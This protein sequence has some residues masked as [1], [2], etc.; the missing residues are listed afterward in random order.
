M[1]LIIIII[2]ICEGSKSGLRLSFHANMLKTVGEK[3][4]QPLSKKSVKFEVDIRHLCQGQQS[5]TFLYFSIKHLKVAAG[6]I[7][8]LVRV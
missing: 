7:F 4:W 2:I 8:D 6:F 5:E 3:Q 1:E